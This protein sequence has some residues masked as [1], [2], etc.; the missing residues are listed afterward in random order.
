M[1]AVARSFNVSRQTVYL[2]LERRVQA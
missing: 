1:A 2:A